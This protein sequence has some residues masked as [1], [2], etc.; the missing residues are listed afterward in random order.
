MVGGLV[1]S[2]YMH[3][4]A[5]V[6]MAD[7]SL[8]QRRCVMAEKYHYGV[9]GAGRQGVAAAYDMAKWG[10]AASVVIADAHHDLAIRAA[11]RIN[12]LIGREIVSA[13]QVN[14]RDHQALV[15]LLKPIDVFLCA[16][17]FVFIPDCMRAALEAGA[18]MV[19][20]GG[21][22]ETV[23]KQLAMNDEACAAG[24]AVVP[25]CG[26]GPGLNNTLAVYTVEQLQARGAI[27]REARIWD[28]GLPQNPPEPWGYQ[29]SFH[30]NGL[31][32]EYYGQA[33]VLRNGVVTPVDTLTELE[34]VEF[35]GIGTFEAFV[36]SG[37]TS[38]VPYTFEGIL[39]VY[40]NKTL[41][42]PGHYTQF[43]A[44]KDLGLFREEPF[45]VTPTL[46][47]NPRQMYHALLRPMLE[48]ERV[49]DI[50][51]MRAKGT[52]EKDGQDISLV[53][54]LVDRYDATTGFTAME[55]LTGW[56]AAIMVQF[57]A[58]GEVPH[59]AWSLEKAISST[60]FVDEV[61]R[62]GFHIVERWQ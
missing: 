21:H 41:R 57:I 34:M 48:T 58:R 19:D 7:E 49:I 12:K 10:D 46:S 2:Q 16:V 6:G 11:D 23:L 22:T 43:K 28:G 50:C 30:I 17:P 33:L 62:R 36:T 5:L 59:G 27:P 1:D 31:T 40:E 9:V 35:E 47:V 14:V 54:D 13:A 15:D 53:V 18:S 39:Q 45:A 44:F 3:L 4:N 61:R 37:G 8:Q 56:H 26:M 20:L 55:R 60:R 29:C 38:T 52:G 51:V 24:I 42:Y 25:D 32:N